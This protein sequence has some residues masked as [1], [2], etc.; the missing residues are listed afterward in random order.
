M[1]NKVPGKIR[2]VVL[3][4]KETNSKMIVEVALRNINLKEVHLA[5]L[6]ST[7]KLFRK[8]ESIDSCYVAGPQSRLISIFGAEF[9]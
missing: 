5:F 6:T 9:K 3:K 1:N 2:A 4:F 7:E 8:E